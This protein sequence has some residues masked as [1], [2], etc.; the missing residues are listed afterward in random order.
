MLTDTTMTP[1]STPLSEAAYNLLRERIVFLEI[2]PGEPINEASIATELGFGR[3]PVREALK[4]LEADHLAVS[5]P[6]RG[7]FATNVDL[8][9]L[10]DVGEI[11]R[12]LEPLA[13]RRAAESAGEPVRDEMAR[14]V[15]DLERAVLPED[16]SELLR[17]DN[18]VHRLMYT[19]SGNAHLIETL[20]RLDDIATRIWGLLLNRVEGLSDHIAEHQSLL[21]AILDGDEDLAAD[22]AEAHV[23]H[24][25]EAVQRALRH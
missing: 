8:G 12:R 15:A 10:G 5:Y 9:E 3:T 1:D 21:T 25:T 20:T 6:R 18:H 24:F 14:T 2:A 16:R 17:H 7:T 11:R 23:D 13:A 4:R 22:L 19:A